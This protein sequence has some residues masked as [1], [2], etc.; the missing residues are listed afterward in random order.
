MTIVGLSRKCAKATAQLDKALAT[1][2]A[3]SV[4]ALALKKKAKGRDAQEVMLIDA[5]A[6][7]LTGGIGKAQEYCRTIRDAAGTMY[8]RRSGHGMDEGGQ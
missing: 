7:K 1:A 3:I 2:R 5:T 4:A 8:R 6:L